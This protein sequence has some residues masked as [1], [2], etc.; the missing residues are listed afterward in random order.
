[1]SETA[2]GV[3]DE[4]LRLSRKIE[5]NPGE[6]FVP[7]AGERKA[8]NESGKENKKREERQDEVIRRLGSQTRNIIGVYPFPNT[9]SD[10]FDRN[11]AF[12]ELPYGDTVFTFPHL[13][14]SRDVLSGLAHWTRRMHRKPI[15]IYLRFVFLG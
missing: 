14:P 13:R 4:L 1:V 3:Q 9:L 5:G 2:D 8:S 6:G 12:S 7:Q 11:R 10:L 15:P